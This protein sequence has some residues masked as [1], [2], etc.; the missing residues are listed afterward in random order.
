MVYLYRNTE[1]IDLLTD[2]KSAIF[3]RQY[4][5][6]GDFELVLPITDIQPGD[7][8]KFNDYWW[9]VES[10]QI[11]VDDTMCELMTVRG[12]SLKALLKQRVV[13]EQITAD[14]NLRALLKLVLD[15]NVITPS[16]SHRAMDIT[17]TYPDSMGS[18]DS[19]QITVGELVGDVLLEQCA[20]YDYYFEI[21]YNNG[22]TLNFYQGS[23]IPNTVFSAAYDNISNIEYTVNNAPNTIVVG[24]E[25]EGTDQ[26]VV[27]TGSN[28]GLDRYETYVDGS[29]VSSNG[30]IITQSEYEYMLI[31]YGKSQLTAT[32]VES[33]TG[34]VLSNMYEYGADYDLGDIA[35]IDAY[36]I[37]VQSRITE[38]IYS[39]D[40]TGTNIVPTFEEW[41]II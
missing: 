30:E 22:L 6:Y 7:W 38:V 3:N 19:T 20:E 12:S 4:S 5:G 2:Y 27:S 28:T 15:D 37:T 1:P 10:I 24:G 21:T 14:T 25:G 40:E 18:I 26:T 34:A 32:A 17:V 35:T 8:L 31:N 23:E 16:D 33:I 36:G 11:T 9:I 13:V 41:R 29:G 39:I